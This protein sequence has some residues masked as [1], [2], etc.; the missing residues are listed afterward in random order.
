MHHDLVF[1]HVSRLSSGK[2]N[3][4]ISTEKADP[5]KNKEIHNE[6][7]AQPAECGTRRQRSSPCNGI[8]GNEESAVQAIYVTLNRWWPCGA[9]ETAEISTDEAHGQG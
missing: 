8:V 6:R 5:R 3:Y 7:H 9:S 1:D 2:A 4:L